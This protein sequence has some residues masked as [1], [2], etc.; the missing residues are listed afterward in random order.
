MTAGAWSDVRTHGTKRLLPY[1]GE[2][3]VN[4]WN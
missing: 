1:L 2:T 4:R 3:Q